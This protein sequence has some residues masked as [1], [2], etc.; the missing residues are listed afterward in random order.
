MR[1]GCF[2]VIP[3]FALFRVVSRLIS[4]SQIGCAIRFGRYG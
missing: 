3:D 4:G 1:S 2:S